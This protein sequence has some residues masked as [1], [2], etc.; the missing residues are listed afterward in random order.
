M[1]GI[2]AHQQN[3]P[4]LSLEQLSSFLRIL[5]DRTFVAA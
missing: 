2:G 3:H 1:I 5:P 4:F